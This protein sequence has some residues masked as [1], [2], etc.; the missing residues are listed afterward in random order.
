MKMQATQQLIVFTLVSA[1]MTGDLLASGK[2]GFRV[3]NTSEGGISVG[4]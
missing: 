2:F 4:W 3:R 1:I